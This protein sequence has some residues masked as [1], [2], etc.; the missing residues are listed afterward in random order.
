[1]PVAWR[2]KKQRDATYFPETGLFILKNLTTA[3]KH[4]LS[5]WTNRTASCT[6]DPTESSSNEDGSP[7]NVSFLCLMHLI[8]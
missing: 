2:P 1:M 8:S 7:M 5:E 3:T 4:A 6:E